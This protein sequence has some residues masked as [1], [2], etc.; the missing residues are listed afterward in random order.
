ML[1]NII[2]FLAVLSVLIISHECGHFIAARWGG[3]KVEK[4][5]IGFG[6]PIIRVKY[7]ETL[8]LICLVPLG[9]YVK[10]AG[11]D[12]HDHTGGPEEFL[13][14]SPGIK[15]RVVFFGPLFNYL[16]AFFVFWVVF[17]VGFPYTAPTIGQIIADT[18]AESAGL[19][20]GDTILA[21]N[22]EAVDIWSDVLKTISVSHGVLHMEI[23]R[24]G[25][26]KE[27]AVVPQIRSRKDI[28]GRLRELPFVGIGPSFEPKVVRSNIAV[29]FVKA[30]GHVGELTVVIIK[31]L[32]FTIIGVIPFR[33]A[34]A[35]P[36]GI[37]HLTSEIAKVGL[38]PLIHFVGVLS[39]SLGLIN[40]FPIPVLDGG[41]IF[42]LGLE[43]LR[44]K[45][46]PD[47]WE[48]TLTK[49]GLVLLIT[50]MLFI[51]F[52]DVIRFVLHR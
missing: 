26:I 35:G 4:F 8:F 51:V 37:Y 49:I 6:P 1:L 18:P 9:G 16:L 32:V 11:D 34:V 2:I 40:L 43:R 27:V 29:A 15:A 46:L 28:F 25:Q 50:L 48:E 7:K 20:A 5:A 44:K 36:V 10:L 47:K 13:S 3:I 22:G 45:P 12:R 52:N 17:T 41:H 19:I 30:I 31:G 21:I 33:E 23:D 24:A 38:I 39:V 14:K 42:F